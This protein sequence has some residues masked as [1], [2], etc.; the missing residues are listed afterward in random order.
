[1]IHILTDLHVGGTF[2][3]WSLH[4]LAGHKTYFSVEKNVWLELTDNPLN[5]QNA[6]NF[7][8]NQPNR[9]FNCTEQQFDSFIKDLENT[10]TN[11]F[12]TLYFH[13]FYSNTTLAAI[14]Y[15]NTHAEK[16][17]IVDSSDHPLYH[18]SYRK[19]SAMPVGI[20]AVIKGDQ[21]IQNFIIET[22][23]KDSKK[24]WDQC[25]LNEVWDQREFLALN[26]KP[27]EYNSIYKQVDKSKNHYI[28]KSSELWTS[29]DFTV[30]TLF[31]YLGVVIDQQ[32][33]EHWQ[34]IYSQWR[35]LHCQKL[36]F[37]TYFNTII[38]AILNNHS[39]D[40]LRFDL[41]IEQEAAIQHALIYNHGLNLKTWQLEKFVNTAQLH[42]LL[43]PNT[44]PLSS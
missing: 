35:L 41:D 30:T 23:F 32:R 12:H 10:P 7:I 27:F 33:F 44:H 42:N 21:E 38:D 4:Y 13:Q 15:S 36:E 22:Y 8:P 29:F 11:Q 20:N 5:K 17:I 28:I 3:T 31:E 24:I 14:N 16:L 1:M 43:E 40:L 6:H 26:L 2:L 39:I 25:N 19:R 9:I 18:C 37:S 34:K